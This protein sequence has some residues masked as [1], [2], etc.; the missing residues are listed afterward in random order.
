MRNISKHITYA[1]ATASN[2]AK[3]HGI[4]NIPT[5]RNI[6]AMENLA[7][8]IFEKVRARDNKPRRINSFFRN[9]AV[10]DAVGGSRMSQHCKGEAMDFVG[11]KE[12][13][14]YIVDNLEFDQIIWEYGNNDA[15]AWIHVSLKLDGKNRKQVLRKEYKQ[16]YALFT[17]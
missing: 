9:G 16:A 6:T 12:D 8:N 2:V 7:E 5:V 1:E 14:W 15:P 13:F 11:S 17:K 10:N 3:R 4:D